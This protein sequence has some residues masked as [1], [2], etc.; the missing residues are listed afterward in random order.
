M[1]IPNIKSLLHKL[2]T[3]EFS[4]RRLTAALLTFSIVLTSTFFIINLSNLPNFPKGEPLETSQTPLSQE[5]PAQT[6]GLPAQ[7]P[8]DPPVTQDPA[9]TPDA[10]DPPDGAVIAHNLPKEEAVP[11]VMY[12][13][14]F[15]RNEF[16]CDCKPQAS[17]RG[18]R[19]TAEAGA[20]VYSSGH[21]KSSQTAV[22]MTSE[23]YTNLK[24]NTCNGLPVEMDPAF[25]AKLE[26][27]RNTLGRPVIVTSGVR[28]ATRNA[29]VGG[30]EDSW[31]LTGHAADIYC[32]GVPYYEVAAIARELGVGV[33]AYA[34]Q[35]YCHI[36]YKE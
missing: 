18:A 34:A 6:T 29:E 12:T 15:A 7:D 11:E 8:T 35:Q 36:E 14:H 26:E 5:E 3:I 28:C 17:A 27:L 21:E 25:M 32:P 30:I 24:E 22:S 19:A 16:I 4:P 9:I 33:V 23:E 20:K 31:H 2:K 1:R 10:V 13:A